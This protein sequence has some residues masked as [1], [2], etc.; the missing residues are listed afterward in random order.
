MATEVI[1]PKAGMAMERGTVIQW[2]KKPGDYVEAG[3]PLLEIETD[4]VAMEVEAEVSGFLLSILHDAGDEVEVIKTIGYIGEKGE[5]PPTGEAGGSEGGAGADSSG[6]ETE[7]PQPENKE[8]TSGGEGATTQD[9]GDDAEP[10]G[11]G[12]PDGK[13]A[14][15][16]AARR[17]AEEL[18]LSLSAATAT[19]NWGEVRER[20]VEAAGRSGSGAE[21]QVSPLARKLAQDEGV[22]LATVTGTGPGGRIVKRDVIAAAERAPASGG[23][24]APAGAATGAAAATPSEGER[25]PLRGMR[26]T[27]AERMLESHQTVPPVTLNRKVRVSTLFALREQ[28]NSE[29]EE[30]ISLNDFIVKAVAKALVDAPYMRTILQGDELVEL[31]EINIGIAVALEEGLLVPVVRNVDRLTLAELSIQGKDLARRARERKLEAHELQNGCFTVTNLGMFGISSFTPIINLP[32][33]A[34]LGVNGAEDELYLEEGEVKSRKVMTLSLT[35][36]HRIIDGAQGAIFLDKLA[37]L[38]ENPMTILI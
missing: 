11:T 3:E 13:I 26:K 1:M 36:D 8:A 4:K 31:P 38:L 30:R 17:R 34:I 7:A 22:D 6:A 35:I 33:S 21:P 19:G 37:K 32:Q 27:I 18:G 28:I 12:V 29:V 14:A 2:F 25:K 5:A 23:A 9:A 16:P 15:T 20:D 24:G 10:A